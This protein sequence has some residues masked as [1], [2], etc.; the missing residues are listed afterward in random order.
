MEDKHWYKGEPVGGGGEDGWRGMDREG[1]MG[2]MDREGWME[3][4][5][6]GEMDGEKW[7]GRDRWGEMDGQGWIMRDKRL[8]VGDDGG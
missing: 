8:V 2:R 7:M 6:W 1:W 5:E 4:D 3:R